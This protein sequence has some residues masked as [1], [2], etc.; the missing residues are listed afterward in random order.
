MMMYYK[1]TAS[2]LMSLL[3]KLATVSYTAYVYRLNLGSF[4]NRHVKFRLE[5]EISFVFLNLKDSEN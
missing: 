2:V 3:N 4:T 5:L 1:Y